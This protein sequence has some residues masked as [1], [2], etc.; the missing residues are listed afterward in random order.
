MGNSRDVVQYFLKVLGNSTRIST[1]MEHGEVKVLVDGTEAALITDDI[2]YVP[3][4][5]ASAA[6]ER[7]C[8]TDIPYLGATTH[9][10]IDE[11][12]VADVPGLAKILFAVAKSS[13]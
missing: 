7:F 1:R 12:Q 4:C 13:V 2:L 9:Y 8:E 11:S 3:V 5:P 10:V 6:L